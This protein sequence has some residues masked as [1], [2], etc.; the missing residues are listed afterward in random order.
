[1]SVYLSFF[2]MLVVVSPAK[3]LDFV[4]PLPTAKHS[5]PVLIERSEKL[6]DLMVQKSPAELSKMMSISASLAD[7]NHQRFQDWS[8][9]FTPDNARPAILAFDGDTYTGID[10]ARSFSERDY[11]HSQK[12]LRILSGLHGVL[13]PLDLIQPYRLEMGSKLTH[14][15]GSDLYSYWVGEVTDQ[16]NVALDKSPGPAMLINLASNEYF[17]AVQ[18]D[19]LE[20]RIIAPRFLDAKG[21]GDFKVV[22][23]FA[24]QARGSMAG[25]IVRERIVTVNAIAD[26]DIGGYSFDAVRSTSDV[27]V[28]TRRWTG[29]G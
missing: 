25:W 3:A 27:P 24:K 9:P 18:P 4:S 22:S 1:M 19:R 5:Q 7:L 8:T 6:V 26:F 15:N 28:F 2:I 13:R 16:L 17:A 14:D 10:A 20:G 11:T 29:S 12:V 21:E 23:F